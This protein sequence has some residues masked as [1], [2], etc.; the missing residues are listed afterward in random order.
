MSKK[1]KEKKT[2]K[3]GLQKFEEKYT[4][5]ENELKKTRSKM[6]KLLAKEAK[7]DIQDYVLKDRD[8]RD[9]M[10]SEMFEDKKEL[11]VVHNM[12]K[13]CSYCTLWADGFSGVSYFIERKAAFVLISPDPPDVQKAFASERGWK[14][15]MYSGNDSPFIKDMGYVTESGSYWP[16]ASV[17]HKDNEGKITRISKT[18]FGPGDD[19]CSVWHFLD[20]LPQNGEENKKS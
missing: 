19:Y 14:F 17:F 10:L 12:G 3:N 6:L 13:S 8:G 7:M 2:K 18:Y 15:K 11:I 4:K 5:L 9:I 16:G 20:M 1:I